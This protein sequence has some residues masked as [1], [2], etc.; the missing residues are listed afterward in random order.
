MEAKGRSLGRLLDISRKREIREGGQGGCGWYVLL[1]STCDRQGQSLRP[2]AETFWVDLILRNPLDT[3]ITLSA[4]TVVVRDSKSGDPVS[5]I[6]DV[7]V[8]D[9]ITLNSRESRTVSLGYNLIPVLG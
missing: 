9:D 5:E 3:E 7:E 6:V 8:V 4:L 1:L 2:P